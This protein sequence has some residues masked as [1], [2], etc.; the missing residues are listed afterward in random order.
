MDEDVDWSAYFENIRTQCPWSW[1]AYQKNQID[2]TQWQG[3][4]LPLGDYQARVYVCDLTEKDLETLCD[5]LDQ[6]LVDEWLFSCPGYGPWATPVPV[7]I[8]QDR[9]RLEDLRHAINSQSNW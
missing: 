2:I 1:Q 9:K 4:K 6:D 5:Q 7:L 3:Q 8:Q